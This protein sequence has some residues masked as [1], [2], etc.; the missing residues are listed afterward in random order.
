VRAGSPAEAAT[1]DDAWL[2]AM[3]DAE[4]AL[5]RAQARLGLV[6]AAA[7]GTIT[8]VAADTGAFDA[9]GIA[10]ASR[11]AAHP[12]VA[13]VQALT[14]AVAAAD[15]AAADFVHRGSTAQDI[16]DT[17]TMLVARRTL[18]LVTAD[19]ERTAAALA[20]LAGAHR[21]TLLPARTLTQHAVPTTFGLKAAGWLQGV[22][23]ALERLRALHDGGL[24]IELGG[25]GGTLAGY[26]EYA[27]TDA[28]DS[29]L[30]RP[31]RHVAELFEAYAAETGLAVPIAPWHTVRT[32]LADLAAGL[33]L[34][35][36][37]L[38][39]FA[40]D[41]QVLSRTEVQEA[42]EPAAP[43]RGASSAMPQKVNPVL[44][45]LVRQAAAQVPLLAAVVTQSLIAE[46]ERPA[47]A[48]HAEWQPLR[49]CLRL[50]GGAARTAA[51]LAAGLTV[52]PGRMRANLALSGA[53]VVTERL[54]VVL[55]PHLGRTAAKTAVTSACHEARTGNCSL[56]AVLA[57]IP[58]VGGLFARAEL[59]ALA[60]PAAY[61]GAAAALVD[62][63]LERYRRM[64]A[65]PPGA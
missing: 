39:K 22:L 10:V 25:A 15:P 32:P 54:A 34:T 19:L 5:A 62:R 55:A 65:P 3:L 23:D 64:V 17:A 33:T 51:E 7:A 13:L 63:V 59:D 14:T 24:P 8:R 21:D 36:G 43:G 53:G 26:L 42:A 40:A 20:R 56:A 11:G 48:W 52:D 57:G 45:T 47:G 30:T 18:A 41:V 46:D 2:R 4:A 9:R 6:P 37:V 49:E 1:G 12:V 50:T 61:T 29:P 60:D 35:A 27:R 31:E 38:G 16:L 44:A 28:P 58:A